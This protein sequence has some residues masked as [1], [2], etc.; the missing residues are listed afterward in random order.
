MIN[1]IIWS[2]IL[3]V[4]SKP[5]IN[6]T[7]GDTGT[8][9]N[10]VL[11]GAP[12]NDIKVA[13]TPIEIEMP[14][15]V[16]EQS[17]HTCYVFKNSISTK[18]IEGGTHSARTITF[19]FNVHKNYVEEDGALVLT[20]KD[21]GPGGLW[22]LP[23]EVDG[24]T[25]LDEEEPAQERQ[26]PPSIAAATVHTLSYKQQQVKYM[27]QTFFAMPPAMLEKSNK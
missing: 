16:I 20:G 8:T 9:E 4:I 24:Q 15:G 1:L 19:L 26:N 11:S 13:E 3:W 23:I 27:H 5:R 21:I 2:K 18:R 25:S 12:V 22:I 17:I 6:E 7:I 14:N 10:F